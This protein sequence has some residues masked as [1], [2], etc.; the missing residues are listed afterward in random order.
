MVPVAP[1]A[2]PRVLHR[3]HV[4]QDPHARRVGIEHE[5]R[6]PLMA[7][8]IRVGDRHHD[9]EVGDRA[10][11]GEPLATVDDPL[12]AVAHGGGLQQRRIRSGGVG[13]GHAEG[14]L[15]IAGQQWMQV[16]IFLLGRAGEREDLRVARV[17]RRIAERERRDRARAQDLVH[18]AE[19][20][21]PVALTAELGVQVSCP[22]ALRPDLVLERAHRPDE[23]VPTQF[24]QDQS[25]AA[26][27][28]RG[29][30]A[31]P[32]ELALKFGV[33][34]EVPGHS[35]QWSL[36]RHP[37]GLAPSSCM[38]PG[39]SPDASASPRPAD[40][41]RRVLPAPG[42]AGVAYAHRCG[43]AVRG[44]STRL[45]RLPRPRARPPASGAALPPEAGH[46]AAG[47]RSPAVDRR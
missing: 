23:P 13:L 36:S 16:A 32:V 29:R 12:V 28:A 38:R 31:H 20:D 9:Q 10:V 2:F 25:R 15:Q 44:A 22:Q 42:G 37:V 47:D 4:A 30:T 7:T 45:H 5:H 43:A 8:G 11:G 17:G 46:P 1:E 40:F 34:G 18:E 27:S 26:R 21:L 39:G 6:G 14:G 33:G 19:L 24:R 35:A 3:R 41:H